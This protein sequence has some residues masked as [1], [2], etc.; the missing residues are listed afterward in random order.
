MVV[1]YSAPHQPSQVCVPALYEL[2]GE[3]TG[4][5]FRLVSHL[6]DLCSSAAPS[7]TA[8]SGVFLLL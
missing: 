2:R 8:D 1:Q 3:G 5:S 6:P 4:F 7:V